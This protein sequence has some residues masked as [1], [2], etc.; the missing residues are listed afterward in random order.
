MTDRL[1]TVREAAVFLGRSTSW[2]YKAAERGELPRAR[3]MGWGLR[4]VPSELQAYALGAVS[5]P[6]AMIRRREGGE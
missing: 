2:V 6:R 5:D 1:W 3:G 4:F